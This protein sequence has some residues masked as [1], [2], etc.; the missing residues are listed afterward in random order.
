[1]AAECNAVFLYLPKHGILIEICR[2]KKS[3][4]PRSPVSEH[5][6]KKCHES[7]KEQR[8][9]CAV[10]EVLVETCALSV[11]KLLPQVVL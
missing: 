4:A 1:M 8:E 7:R 3:T 9:L 10:R 6:G 11:Q 5:M 2:G